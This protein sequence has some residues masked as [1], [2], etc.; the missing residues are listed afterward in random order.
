MYTLVISVHPVYTTGPVYGVSVCLVCHQCTQCTLSVYIQYTLATL[1]LGLG[2]NNPRM[3]M[4]GRVTRVI[5]AIPFK[6]LR[7]GGMEKKSGVGEKIKICEGS[8]RN[9]PFRPLSGFQME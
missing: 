7:G 9:F 8:P 2:W 3:I 5:R 1:G 4:M 6:I